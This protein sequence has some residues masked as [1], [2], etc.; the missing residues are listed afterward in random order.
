MPGRPLQQMV[1]CRRCRGS[2]SLSLSLQVS[3]SNCKLRSLRWGLLAAPK[4]HQTRGCAVLTRVVVRPRSV[5]QTC[6]I[7]A[8]LTFLIEH[9]AVAR[10]D[11]ADALE[12]LSIRVPARQQ[13]WGVPPHF[14]ALAV[15]CAYRHL[16]PRHYSCS[17]NLANGVVTW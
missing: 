12:L 2:D 16:H 1:V 8:G 4:E 15:P 5:K 7:H 13:V 14:T 9:V 3:E 11:P 10:H 6:R 17:H